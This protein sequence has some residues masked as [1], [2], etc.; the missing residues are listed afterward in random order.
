ME[1]EIIKILIADDMEAHRRR[2]NRIIS[3]QPDMEV[4]GIAKS[5][6]EAVLL[7]ATKRPDIILMDIEMESKTAGI[8]SAEQINQNLPDIKIIML[9]VHQDESM[10]FQSY[11][12][13]IVDYMI[14]TISNEGLISG[15][16]HAYEGNSPIRAEIAQ[17]IRNE[18]KRLRTHES[19]LLFVVNNISQLTVSELEVLKLF[20]QH[21]TKKQIAAERVVEYDTIKKQTTSILKKFDKE[22]ISDVVA[23]I[24]ELNLLDYL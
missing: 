20:C 2:L 22:N 3:A 11:Q 19:S 16:R 8:Q 10:I 24:A 7:S 4:V 18:F 23:L 17:I 21:K 1:H 6:Y 14:K 9:T 12:S 13:G 5:G 15:I